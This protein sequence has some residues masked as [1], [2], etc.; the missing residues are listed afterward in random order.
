MNGSIPKTNDHVIKTGLGKL[1]KLPKASLMGTLEEVM[2]D[3]DR[4]ISLSIPFRMSSA[5]VAKEKFRVIPCVLSPKTSNLLVK[6][7]NEQEEGTPFVCIDAIIG[8]AD[9]LYAVVKVGLADTEA[10]VRRWVACM[11]EPS[12]VMGS[13]KDRS[14]GMK[15]ILA[16]PLSAFA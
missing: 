15:T 3:M 1:F 14:E 11:S 12:L 8:G 13:F 2:E 10:V 6:M 7:L 16:A 4:S 5:T 9:G